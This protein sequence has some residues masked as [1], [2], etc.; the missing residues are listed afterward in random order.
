MALPISCGNRL[1]QM[2]CVVGVLEF[3]QISGITEVEVR[4]LLATAKRRRMESPQHRV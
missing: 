2:V 1:A 3:F 4:W